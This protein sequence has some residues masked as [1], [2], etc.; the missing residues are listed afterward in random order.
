MCVT[1]CDGLLSLIGLLRR[2][3]VI[4]TC[5]KTCPENQYCVHWTYMNMAGDMCMCRSGYK[6]SDNGCI[7]ETSISVDVVDN[8]SILA[9]VVD[10][11]NII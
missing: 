11:N 3:S 4:E 1:A 7:S 5:S 10:N 8:T 2:V 9:T 6:M